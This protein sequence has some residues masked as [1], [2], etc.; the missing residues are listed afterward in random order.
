VLGNHKSGTTVFSELI[1]KACCFSVSNG[2][3][4]EI[5]YPTY[6][7]INN[8][9]SNFV[10][11]INRNKYDFSFDIIHENQL[12][13]FYEFLTTYFCDSKFLLVLRDPRDNIRSILNRFNI[14]GNLRKATVQELLS[15]LRPHQKYILDNTWLDVCASNYIESLAKRWNLIAK[16]YLENKENIHLVYYEEFIKDKTGYINSVIREMNLK[17]TSDIDDLVDFQYQ[18]KGHNKVSW[19]DFFGYKNLS[20]IEEICS[21]YMKKFKYI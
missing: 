15:K 5:I 10:Q 4:K 8:R 13:F 3:K 1:G 2:L 6:N 20:L 12:T 17:K 14:P 9:Y 19:E 18:P 7:E 11:L 21:D 16:I